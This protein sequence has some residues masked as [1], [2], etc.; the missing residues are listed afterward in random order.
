MTS[1]GRE[2]LRALFESAIGAVIPDRCLQPHLP[3]P[4][5]GRTVIVGAGKAT[6]A[7]ARV[8][9]DHYGKATAGLVITRYGHGV[10]ADTIGGIEVVEA[11]HPIPDDAGFL[12][13]TRILEL[14]SAGAAA[15]ISSFACCPAAGRRCLPCPPRK[16]PLR[17]SRW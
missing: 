10:G 1:D 2:L 17:T 13:S 4:P 12:A 8:A 15:M 6:A 14:G 16:I 11:G 7:M 5:K 3:R 9:A